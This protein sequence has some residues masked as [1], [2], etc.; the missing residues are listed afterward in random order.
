MT[1]A[2]FNKV[3]SNGL[4][5]MYMENSE[6]LKITCDFSHSGLESYKILEQL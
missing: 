6:C 5:H 2:I 1:Q 4:F 3:G